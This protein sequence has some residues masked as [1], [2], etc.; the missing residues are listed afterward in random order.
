MRQIC[1]KSLLMLPENLSGH[2]LG[3]SHVYARH[4]LRAVQQITQNEQEQSAMSNLAKVCTI[5]QS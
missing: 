4:A 1:A 2:L 3:F 5:S